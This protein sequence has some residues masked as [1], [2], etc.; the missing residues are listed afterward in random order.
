[1]HRRNSCYYDNFCLTTGSNRLEWEVKEPVREG[2]RYRGETKP[3]GLA[4]RWNVVAKGGEMQ[5]LECILKDE[6]KGFC[7][8]R[9]Q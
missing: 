7:C 9:V 4:E 2:E 8:C 5:F 3:V 1:M 6:G